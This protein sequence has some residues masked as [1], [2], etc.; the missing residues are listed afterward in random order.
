MTPTGTLEF[1]FES[2]RTVTDIKIQTTTGEQL[3]VQFIST[4]DALTP[5]TPIAPG[6]SQPENNPVDESNVLVVRIT[7]P[8]G[9]KL[10]PSDIVTVTVEACL[11][12]KSVARSVLC[13]AIS[14]T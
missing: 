1:R 14:T 8:D 13:T 7:R 4:E 2:P 3:Q 11:P 9:Q 10:S 5:P 12:R 6:S